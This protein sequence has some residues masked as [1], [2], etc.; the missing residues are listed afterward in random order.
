MSSLFL[1]G[2]GASCF[3]GPCSPNA[4]PLGANL[5]QAL[6]AAGGVAATVDDDLAKV[7]EKDFEAGMD[8][9]LVERNAQASE[10]LRDM[11]RF[12]A[13]FEPL[14]ENSYFKLLTLLGGARKKSVIVTTNYD[15]LIEHAIAQ[16]GCL[17]NYG[18][19]STDNKNI[20]VLKIH[21]SCNFLPDTGQAQIAGIAFKV[22]PNHK[23]AIIQ[24]KIKIAQRASEII[25]FCENQDSIG[26]ALALY[27]PAKQVLYCSDFINQIQ[28]WWLEAL[29]KASRIYVIGLRVH[30][31]DEHIWGPLAS[32]VAPIHYVGREPEDF[33]AW[34]KN[35]NRKS[36][37][38]L[39]DSFEAAIPKIATHH[40]Y[41]K[42]L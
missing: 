41:R 6:R 11:A 36:A 25:E 39:A 31:V 7:F 3:S 22:P 23:G 4:P 30:L 16:S 5:F 13:P 35:T 34:A 42:P 26:P 29:S 9:F 17:I 21:G 2:A 18:G 15:L 38:V 12:F 27:S 14:P 19:L 20:P 40:G 1:F 28:Q 37:Y 8:R 33:E 24:T 32:A 10:F